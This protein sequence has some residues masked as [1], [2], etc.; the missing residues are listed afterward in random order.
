MLPLL[1]LVAPAIRDSHNSLIETAREE[2]GKNG[3]ASLMSS[4]LN[5]KRDPQ[6]ID[7]DV[8]RRLFVMIARERNEHDKRLIKLNLALQEI[9]HLLG[10]SVGSKVVAPSLACQLAIRRFLQVP[11]NQEDKDAV[12]NL[13]EHF[14]DVSIHAHVVFATL[15]DI[16]RLPKEKVYSDYRPQ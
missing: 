15:T 10:W 1:Q 9:T 8:K 11:P 5:G 6:S 14:L 13:C 16:L 2:F 3:L 4:Y 7:P 12:N